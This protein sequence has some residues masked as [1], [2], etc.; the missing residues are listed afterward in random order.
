MYDKLSVLHKGHLVP[1]VNLPSD[2]P[3]RIKMKTVQ[4]PTRTAKKAAKHG[5]NEQRSMHRCQKQANLL[6]QLGK[7]NEV[8]KSTSSPCVHKH[9]HTQIHACMLQ[10]LNTNTTFQT[11]DEVLCTWYSTYTNFYIYSD[12][13]NNKCYEKCDC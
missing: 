8:G 4:T 13:P 1:T 11:C 10:H 3:I 12:T 7:D 2:Q 5:S 9:T 6:Q